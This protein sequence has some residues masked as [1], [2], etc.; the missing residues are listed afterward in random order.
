MENHINQ[1]T[2]ENKP[3]PILGRGWGP[4]GLPLDP[5]W[6]WIIVGMGIGYFL[7]NIYNGKDLLLPLAIL[8]LV[9]L[10]IR[11]VRD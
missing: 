10:W 7:F 2:P 6:R 1:E 8:V 9:V 4:L 5:D 11:E 3:M